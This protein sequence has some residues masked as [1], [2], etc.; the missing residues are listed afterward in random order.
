[1]LAL[2]AM[3]VTAIA[4]DSFWAYIRKALL[5]HLVGWNEPNNIKVMTSNS[6]LLGGFQNF[7]RNYHILKLVNY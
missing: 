1:M 6:E 7:G 2:I 3:Q 4:G 5:L